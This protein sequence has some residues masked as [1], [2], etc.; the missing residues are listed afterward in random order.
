VPKAHATQAIDVVVQRDG[1]YSGVEYSEIS[2]AQ[3]PA[4]GVLLFRAGNIANHFYIT[5][6]LRGVAFHVVRKKT[7]WRADQAP[8]AEWDVARDVRLW[9]ILVFSH[10]ERFAVDEV[11][12]AGESFPPKNL[13]ISERIVSE[14]SHRYLLAQ[15]RCFLETPGPT[16][17]GGVEIEV[18]PLVIYASGNLAPLKG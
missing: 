11:A 16:V 13:P 14:I 18:S 10:T 8:E 15:R 17:D 5:V 1:K 2:V 6:F 12:R 7:R 4:T 9:D 3:D